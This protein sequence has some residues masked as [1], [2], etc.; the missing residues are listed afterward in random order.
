MVEPGKRGL[1]FIPKL[2]HETRRLKGEDSGLHSY[3]LSVLCQDR[4]AT[5]HLQ[6]VAS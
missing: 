3:I 1:G 4:K 2:R 6:L 5:C